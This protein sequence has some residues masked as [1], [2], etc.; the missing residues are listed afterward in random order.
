MSKIL[1]N[2]C[3]EPGACL[4][5]FG[6]PSLLSIFAP[7]LFLGFKI[8]IY[9]EKGKKEKMGVVGICHSTCIEARGKLL[10]TMWNIRIELWSSGLVV[11]AFTHWGN[12]PLCSWFFFFW[13]GG[14]F[15]CLF[16]FCFALF[17][18]FKLENMAGRFSVCYILYGHFLYG[19]FCMSHSLLVSTSLQNLWIC[20]II[21]VS[22]QDC[23]H[24]Q[25]TTL[26]ANSSI[27]HY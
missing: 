5:L 13:G 1:G 2:W 12:L 26:K 25:F 20:A 14:L 19:H 15:V 21:W 6:I 9:C 4:Y 16:D 3:I 10:S 8:Y 7:K 22:L 11:S 17:A 24:P 23:L 18:L 27:L